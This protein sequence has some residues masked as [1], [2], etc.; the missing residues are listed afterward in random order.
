MI[1]VRYIS[2]I[3]KTNKKFVKPNREYENSLN[4]IK[5]YKR[6][7]SQ[8]NQFL[9]RLSQP[10]QKAKSIKVSQSKNYSKRGFM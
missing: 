3:L 7:L 9:R 4:Y 1:A 5:K 6:H 10:Q 8:L 2:A